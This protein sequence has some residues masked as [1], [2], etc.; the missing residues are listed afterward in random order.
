[1]LLCPRRAQEH[2]Q[3]L[4]HRAV[5]LH[6]SNLPKSRVHTDLWFCQLYSVLVKIGK[7]N[8]IQGLEGEFRYLSGL[9]S[10]WKTKKQCNHSNSQ[11]ME[12]AQISQLPRDRSNSAVRNAIILVN[13]SANQAKLSWIIATNLASIQQL[14]YRLEESLSNRTQP[15]SSSEHGKIS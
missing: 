11:M 2:A 15:L 5:H 13:I 7:W 4:V 1:M 14:K 10:A 6:A 12:F 9:F 8:E 3:G